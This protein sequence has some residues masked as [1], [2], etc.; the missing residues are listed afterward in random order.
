MQEKLCF[1]LFIHCA[2]YIPV[3]I[4]HS[5][6]L[7]YSSSLFLA[8][9]LFRLSRNRFLFVSKIIYKLQMKMLCLPKSLHKAF[10]I[11]FFV[12]KLCTNVLYYIPRFDIKKKSS[13]QIRIKRFILFFLL[14]LNSSDI[15]NAISSYTTQFG[16]FKYCMIT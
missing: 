5:P 12:R 6:G 14:N 8:L 3:S 7:T 1:V 10:G 9:T 13:V 4:L 15:K 11:E 16:R 2:V